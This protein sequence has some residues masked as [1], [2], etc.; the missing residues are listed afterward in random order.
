MRVD[1]EICVDSVESAIAAD[2]GGAQRVELCC[3]LAEGG[4]TPS[5]GAI[6]LARAAV[7]LGLCVM[8]RPRG[9]DFVYSERDF[10]VMLNDVA[11]AKALGADG[12][13]LGVLTAA[14]AVDVERT[15][16]LV[17]SARPMQVTFHKAFD[18]A[19]DLEQALEDVIACGADRVL[20]SGGAQ[21]AVAGAESIARLVRQADGRIRV[22][23][24]GSVRAGNVGALVDR[25]G[26]RDVHTSLM[27][28]GAAGA[29]A[30]MGAEP[31]VV[32][33]EDVR[34]M[35]EVLGG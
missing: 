10:A 9:G 22:M 21:D 28:C 13:V 5:A 12:V 30:S 11:N 33:V 6:R 24:G 25:T 20:T 17:E 31:F 35:L 2:R 8:I 15:R 18:V 7:G 34:G 29:K 3:A 14:G 4:L 26:V 16:R 19:A 1:L 27:P 32:R 23:A